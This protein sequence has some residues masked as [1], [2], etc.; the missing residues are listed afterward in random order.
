[1]NEEGC[2]FASSDPGARS[3]C[4]RR[5]SF[6]AKRTASRS[7]ARRAQG[8]N[9]VHSRTRDGIREILLF[10]FLS[11]FWYASPLC[12]SLSRTKDDRI[13]VE[14]QRGGEGFRLAILFRTTTPLLENR[15]T[16]R[17]II[18]LRVINRVPNPRGAKRASA[19]RVPP[20]PV[21]PR[22]DVTASQATC[23][24]WVSATARRTSTNTP[25]STP[26][27]NSR[28]TATSTKVTYC[29]GRPRSPVSSVL[30][31]SPST[32]L[33]PCKFAIFLH[34]EREREKSRREIK[35]RRTK[36]ENFCRTKC[37]SKHE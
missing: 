3:R 29:T 27:M 37:F 8:F 5:Y 35:R 24:P 17:R 18:S 4:V 19:T 22:R 34:R 6:R 7:L 12:R 2:S 9:P 32:W 33:P 23:T 21:P 10:V 15:V 13:T 30:V 36:G 1:M 20:K 14:G 16:Y 28:R 31:H 11:F 25:R 26:R